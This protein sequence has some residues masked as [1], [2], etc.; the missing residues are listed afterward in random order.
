MAVAGAVMLPLASLNDP[1]AIGASSDDLRPENVTLLQK[2]LRDSVEQIEKLL[3]ERTRRRPW[4][5]FKS[6]LQYVFLKLLSSAARPFSARASER[7]KRSSTKRQ[8]SQ[9]KRH[10]D[11][12]PTQD[13]AHWDVRRSL[14]REKGQI[15][16][17]P[18]G[19]GK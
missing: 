12:R 9:L 6:Y 2:K 4:L 19:D 14:G 18:G 13:Q 10:L 3:D 17:A 11:A 5:P 15:Q 7:F 16:S 8:P 1:I